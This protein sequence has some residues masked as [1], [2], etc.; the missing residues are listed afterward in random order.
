MAFKVVVPSLFRFLGHSASVFFLA[1]LLS[2]FLAPRLAL[3][4][5]RIFELTLKNHVFIPETIEVKPSEKFKLRI[6]NDDTSSEEF[7][8]RELVIEKF[9][10]PQKSITVTFGPLKAGTYEFVGEF[11]KAT[12]KGKIISKEEPSLQK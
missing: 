12:A 5:E 11:H 10:G 3:A 9:I 2:S 8:S 4:Q 7:E 6:K 1:F